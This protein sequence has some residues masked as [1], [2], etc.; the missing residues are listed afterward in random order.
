MGSLSQSRGIS[1]AASLSGGSWGEP[2]SLPFP[3]PRATPSLA[4]DLSS[5]LKANWH[6]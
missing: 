4:C 3:F 5:T 6:H 2:V 1:R